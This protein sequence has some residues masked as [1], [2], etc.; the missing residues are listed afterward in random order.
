MQKSMLTVASVKVSLVLA[1]KGKAS[2][3]TPCRGN[4][5]Y[6]RQQVITTALIHTVTDVASV[7]T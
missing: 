1:S 4:R 5:K 3:V 6:I 7:V 2:M